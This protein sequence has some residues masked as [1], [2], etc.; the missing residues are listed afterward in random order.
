MSAPFLSLFLLLFWNP[1]PS[2]GESTH[3]FNGQILTDFASSS[4]PVSELLVSRGKVVAVGHQLS[5][6]PKAKRVDLRKAWVIPSFSDSHVHFLETGALSGRIDLRGKS[7]SEIQSNLKTIFKK[8][9]RSQLLVGFGWDQTLWNPPRFPTHSELDS[10]SSQIPIILFRIDGH[11]AWVNSAALKKTHLSGSGI[12]IDKDLDKIEKLIPPMSPQEMRK[13][14]NEAVNRSLSLGITSL[15]DAGI[16]KRDYLILKDWVRETLPPIRLFEMASSHSQ[17]D[18]EERFR[19]GP[20]KGLFEDRLHLRT[21]KIYLDGAL[22]SRGALLESPYSDDPNHNGI[23]M[24]SDSELEALIRKADRG[25]FQVAIHAIGDKANRIAV[26]TFKKIWGKKTK[27]KRPRLEHAQVLSS[28][29]I[30]EIARLGIIASM[31]PVHFQSDK[32]WVQKRLGKARAQFAY[33]WKSL[34]EAGAFLAF[35]SDSPIEDLNPWPGIQV[36]ISHQLSPSQS[37]AAFT[38]GA[39]YASFQEERLGKLLPGFWADFILLKSNPLEAQK[40]KDFSALIKA[41]YF[42]GKK[43]FSRP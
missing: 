7:L 6:P 14:F 37:L 42:S 30:E 21:L 32:R 3:F 20:E 33:P 41:T 4:K 8:K 35:G 23:Q 36:A 17:A 38:E 2:W 10:V 16:S 39:A 11:A 27:L 34:K 1:W 12:I 19:L 13:A 5:P 15:H 28:S 18:L 26:E 29:L 25:G 40:I 22:G 31:Q 9:P 43:V 24:I